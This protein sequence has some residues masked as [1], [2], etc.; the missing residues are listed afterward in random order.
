LLAPPFIVTEPEIDA[1][2]EQLALAI[3]DALAEVGAG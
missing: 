1:I 3:D 2:V